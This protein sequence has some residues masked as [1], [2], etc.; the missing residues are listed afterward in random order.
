MNM[1]S[2][3]LTAERGWPRLAFGA[4]VLAAGGIG[5]ACAH[6]LASPMDKYMPAAAAVVLA[7]M[8]VRVWIGPVRDED[9]DED[10]IY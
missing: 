9:P 8:A 3:I 2:R 1:L 7:A 6:W 10:L 5:L 4:A